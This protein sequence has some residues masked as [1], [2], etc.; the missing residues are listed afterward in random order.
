MIPYIDSPEDILSIE[1]NITD[2]PM[3]IMARVPYLRVVI[4]ESPH[5]ILSVY[6]CSYDLFFRQFSY[7]KSKTR[8]Q[9]LDKF[10]E[11][12][13]IVGIRLTRKQKLAK[14]FHRL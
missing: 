11:I 4:G 2:E 8:Q 13:D 7:L 3:A 10:P 12:A 14:A 1:V 6:T 5:K 9:L